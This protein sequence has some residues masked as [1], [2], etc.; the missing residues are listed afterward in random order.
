L[1][2]LNGKDGNSGL[3]KRAYDLYQNLSDE[4]VAAADAAQNTE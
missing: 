4:A 2:G 3:V 1:N